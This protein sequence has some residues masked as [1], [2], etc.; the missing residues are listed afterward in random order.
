MKELKIATSASLVASIETLR[1][2]VRVEHTDYTDVA[3]VVVSVDDVS[4]GV[5]ARLQATGF[6]IPAFVAV[7]GE[8]QL[9]PDYLP[10]VT[11]V[12]TLSGASKA[13]YMAQLEAAADAYEQALLPPFFKTLKTYV[14]ME[15]ATFACRGIRGASS[16][17][18][19]RPAASSM[20]SMA[21]PCSV[22]ICATPT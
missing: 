21:K 7:E 22:P 3:A 9:S 6:N 10:L 18:N 11:G 20:I 15:N 16:S 12:F 17:A 2:V 4:D 5:L 1:Q 13:F 8:E 19:I 14:E